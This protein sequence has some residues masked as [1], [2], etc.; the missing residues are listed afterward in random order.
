MAIDN[1]KNISN[2]VQL[3]SGNTNI[4]Q[5]EQILSLVFGSV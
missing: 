5:K 2:A 4:A 3:G 1:K